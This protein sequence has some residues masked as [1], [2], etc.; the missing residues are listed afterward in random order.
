MLEVEVTGLPDVGPTA[1]DE[2]TEEPWVTPRSVKLAPRICL[3]LAH[4]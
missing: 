2:G 4:F 3:L 1:A